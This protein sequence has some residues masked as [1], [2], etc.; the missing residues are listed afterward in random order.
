M[1]TSG[2]REGNAQLV[3]DHKRG[4][5]LTEIRERALGANGETITV[6]FF[7][8]EGHTKNQANIG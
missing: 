6:A 2:W 4:Y 7:S 3:F 1:V 8:R 5:V